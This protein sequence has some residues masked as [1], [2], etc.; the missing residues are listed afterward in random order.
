MA[1]KI[2]CTLAQ[3]ILTL[4]G[5]VAAVAKT[6]IL[7]DSVSLIVPHLPPAPLSPNRISSVLFTVEWE[8]LIGEK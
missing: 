6:T 4:V 7:P 1:L 5:V 3:L 2:D 8:K